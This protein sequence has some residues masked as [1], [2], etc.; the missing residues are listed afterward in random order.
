MN[1][2]CILRAQS[3]FAMTGYESGAKG[4]QPSAPARV[5]GIRDGVN[6][7]CGA[8]LALARALVA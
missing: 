3:Q 2:V 8:S 6:T 5:I 1:L 4:S 7:L